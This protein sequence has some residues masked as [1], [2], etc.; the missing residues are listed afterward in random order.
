[1]VDDASRE[2]LKGEPFQGAQ[3][4]TIATL[5]RDGKTAVLDTPGFF[6]WL[7]DKR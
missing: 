2:G 6:V 4:F 5:E 7:N 3:G 1:M